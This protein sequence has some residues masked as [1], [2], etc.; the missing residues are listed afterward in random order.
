MSEI[1][2]GFIE[3]DLEDG[4]DI[5]T[6]MSENGEEIDFIEVAGIAYGGDFYEILQP[7]QL[8]EGM[9]EDEALVFKIEQDEDGNDKL[10]IILDDDTIEAVFNEYYKLYDAA[11]LDEDEE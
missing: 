1:K 3:E 11:N 7:V 2:N 8:L 6:L 10:T 9:A 5:I 4:D